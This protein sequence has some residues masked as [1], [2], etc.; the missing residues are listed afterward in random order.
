[1]LVAYE[2][3]CSGRCLI[4][5]WRTCIY[6]VQCVV[7]YEDT[8]ILVAYEDT[9]ILVAYEDT[10]TLVRHIYIYIYIYIHTYI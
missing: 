9:C 1:M 3:T 10:Y 5:L 7:E 2:D 6:I 8:C 4:L